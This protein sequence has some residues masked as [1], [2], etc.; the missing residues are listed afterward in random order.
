MPKKEQIEEKE[1]I[2]YKYCT[3]CETWK[4]YDTDFYTKNVRRRCKKCINKLNCE[5]HK[6]RNYYYT[7]VVKDKR[8]KENKPPKDA[9]V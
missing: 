1:G 9:A 2:K 4:P 5:H 6:T 7:P 3:V 8:K